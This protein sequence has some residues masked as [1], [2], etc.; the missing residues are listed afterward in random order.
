M[1]KMT[2]NGPRNTAQCIVSA[3]CIYWFGLWCLTPLSTIFQ[4]YCGSQF[5]W[6]RKQEYPEKTTD[7][8]QV[9]D[10]LDH[11]MVHRAHFAMIAQVV[12]NPTTIWS[13]Q[14]Q[15]R[16]LL[17]LT[18]VTLRDDLLA[19]S[20]GEHALVPIVYLFLMFIREILAHSISGT[21]DQHRSCGILINLQLNQKHLQLNKK[22]SS[23]RTM[24]SQFMPQ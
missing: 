9:T 19:F 1:N 20:R 13:R 24:A 3:I 15:P 5:Y 17:R 12:V 2:N 22:H 23:P 14:R 18:G 11:I 8:S 7:L 10:K 21:G 16:H 4:L 6:W